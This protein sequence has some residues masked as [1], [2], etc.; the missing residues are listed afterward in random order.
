MRSSTKPVRPSHVL[1]VHSNQATTAS[2][3]ASGTSSSTS[4]PR[5]SSPDSSSSSASQAAT[6]IVEDGGSGISGSTGQVSDIAISVE[7]ERQ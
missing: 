5:T 1:I 7:A 6:V 4:R 2:W 3:V